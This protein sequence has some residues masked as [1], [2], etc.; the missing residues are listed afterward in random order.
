MAGETPLQKKS[1]KPPEKLVL[2]TSL[3]NFLTDIRQELALMAFV[4]LVVKGSESLLLEH[5]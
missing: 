1:K 4:S 3:P 2:M 5:S